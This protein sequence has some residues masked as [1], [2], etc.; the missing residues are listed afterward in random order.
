MMFLTGR[1]INFTEKQWHHAPPIPPLFCPGLWFRHHL[2]PR[3]PPT[4]FVTKAGQAS[5]APPA[6]KS[7]VTNMQRPLLSKSIATSWEQLY[8]QLLQIGPVTVSHRLSNCT[9]VSSPARKHTCPRG[10]GMSSRMVPQR[11]AWTQDTA[12]PVAGVTPKTQQQLRG[13]ER[14]PATSLCWLQPPRDGAYSWPHYYA[15]R[16]SRKLTLAGP[17]HLPGCNIPSCSRFLNHY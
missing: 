4:P 13:Q 14:W 6:T 16:L 10:P 12:A 1:N 15:T 2:Q 9:W 8:W 17:E 7:N 5:E 11:W 3:A